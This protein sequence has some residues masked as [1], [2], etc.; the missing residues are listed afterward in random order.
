MI[1]N[2][3]DKCEKLFEDMDKNGYRRSYPIKV[4]IGRKGEYIFMGGQHRLSFAKILGI[5]E[6]PVK[7]V[8][9]H[10]QWQDTRHKLWKQNSVHPELDD[11]PDVL[12]LLDI[13]NN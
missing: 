9:R 10:K 2:Y 1:E 7:V 13:T 4:A 6:I 11:H 5:D 8:L 3:F 12:E